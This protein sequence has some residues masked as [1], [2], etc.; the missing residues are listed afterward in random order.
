MIPDIIYSMMLPIFI[1][2][3]IPREEIIIGKY[4]YR[5]SYREGDI[6][7]TL[8]KRRVGLFGR[9]RPL[10]SD[11]YE[12]C[13]EELRSRVKEFQKPKPSAVMYAPIKPKDLED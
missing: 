2:K 3:N 1:D 11:T 4:K 13:I 7:K 10:F 9:W 8:E 6:Y 12:K 5:I